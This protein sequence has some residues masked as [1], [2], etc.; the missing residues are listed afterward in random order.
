MTGLGSH[1]RANPDL[2]PR[3]WQNDPLF[4]PA[5]RARVLE[6]SRAGYSSNEIARRIGLSA[7]SVIR[8]RRRDREGN[9]NRLIERKPSRQCGAER[10]HTI[11][12]HTD[13]GPCR[14]WIRPDQTACWRHR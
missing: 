6:M 8:I 1:Q 12:P 5:V 3:G 4:A 10:F 14:T 13:L 7:R 2:L 9:V 11:R